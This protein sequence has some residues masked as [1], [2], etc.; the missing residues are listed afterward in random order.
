MNEKYNKILNNILEKRDISADEKEKI[1]E[2]ID[3]FRH[4]IEKN[5]KKYHAEFFVGGSFAKNTA[6]K[7]DKYDIDV[8]ILFDYIKYREKSNEISKIL[9]QILKKSGYKTEII[10]GSRDYFGIKLR[11]EFD[12]LL[13]V[14]PVLKIKNAKEAKNI[15]DISPLHV[16]YIKNKIKIKNKLSEEIKLAKSFCFSSKCYGAESY[17]GGFSGYSLEVLV[18]YYGS[19]L[20]LLKNVIKWKEKDVIDPE[21]YYKNKDEALKN[22]NTAKM[23]S[24]LILID[25]VQKERNVLAALTK[26]KFDLFKK[27][28]SEFLKHP[29]EKFFE[30]KELNVS[31]LIKQTKKNKKN[32]A[33]F[34]IS[35]NKEKED[36][37]L[38][39]AL[40]FSSFLLFKLEKNGFKIIKTEKEFEKSSMNLYIIYEN[41]VKEFLISGPPCKIEKNCADFRK[42]HKNTTIKNGRIYAKCKREFL[43]LEKFF[44]IF[45]NKE[46]KTIKEMNVKG[47]NLIKFD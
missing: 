8:F 12:I 21:K 23:Q 9:G 5:L 32:L 45:K 35:T 36:I 31:E 7:K 40:K 15:T 16:K 43:D 1:N 26:E 3:K 34:K 33:V 42:K 6:I 47:L 19:F 14:I 44:Y 30:K 18:S 37:A 20:N 22:L 38:A 17:I 13:E 4:S 28:A 10:H 2:I 39:K 29:S 27:T 41:P 25:P 11:S 46:K 24:A